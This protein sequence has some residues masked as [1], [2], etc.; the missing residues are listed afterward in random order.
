MQ[1]PVVSGIYTNGVS[2]F[3]TLY[4]RNLVPVPKQN[5]ISEGYLRPA[6]G[7]VP[8]GIGPGIDRGGINWNG[9]CYRVMGTKLVSIAS[10]GSTTTLADVGGSGQVTMD[11]SFD[12]LGIASGGKLFYWDGAALT[13][14]TDADLGTVVDMKWVDGY[15][16]TTDGEYLVVTELNDPT[17]VNPFKYGSS[18]VDPDEIK[19]ILK[20]RNEIWAMN[21]YTGE[22]FDNVGGENFPFQRIEGAQLP[23]GTI[24]T[25][26]CCVFMQ[27]IAF[28][29]SGR[30]EAIAVWIGNNGSTSKISTREIEQIFTEYTELELSSVLMEARVFDGH[31]FLYIHLPDQTLVFDGAATEVMGVPAWHILTTSIVGNGQYRAKNFVYAYGKWLCGDPTSVNHGYLT[32][33]VSSHYGAVN[34]WDFGTTIIY[35]EGRGALFHEIELVCLSGR[36][37]LGADPTIYTRYSTDGMNWSVERPRS[38]G[39]TGES[40]KRISWLQQG[41]MRHWRCQ[42]FRGTSDSHLT[43]ARLEA[44]IEGMNV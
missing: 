31:Q 4:P 41:F 25:H 7:I 33:A 14:V 44:R 37:A 35:N 24:G 21:R 16:M 19:A 40:V 9:T 36:A 23:R 34:G 12:R 43:I 3:R 28:V 17:S 2:D 42:F 8:F 13:E 29:G 15:F 5:G 10:D 39:K 27:N 18:E 30:N 22:V 11:Y 6:D 26:A 32:D 1:I 38:A 20:L